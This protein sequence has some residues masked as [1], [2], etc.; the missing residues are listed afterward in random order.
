MTTTYKPPK[1]GASVIFLSS[2]VKAGQRNTHKINSKAK[3]LIK[4]CKPLERILSSEQKTPD[5]ELAGRLK[6]MDPTQSRWRTPHFTA[7]Q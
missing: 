6:K 3:W 1:A 4:Q 2:A 7:K 5:M